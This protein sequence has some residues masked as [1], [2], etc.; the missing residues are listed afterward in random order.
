MA[1]IAL[2]LGG[3]K[4]ASAIVDEAGGVKFTHK[5]CFKAALAMKWAGSLS[6][7]LPG[8]L[9]RHSIIAFPSQQ[10]GYVCQAV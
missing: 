6:T 2:D 9:T 10:L 5:T 7:V 8:S 3:T 1:V 4:I